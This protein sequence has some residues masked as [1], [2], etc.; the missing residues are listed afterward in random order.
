MFSSTPD[1]RMALVASYF[2]ALTIIRHF[3]IWPFVDA[4]P[5]RIHAM[6]TRVVNLV[7]IILII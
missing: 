6:L 1:T 5:E 3:E 2:T 4:V 7:E